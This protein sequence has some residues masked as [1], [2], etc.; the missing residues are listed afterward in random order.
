[1]KLRKWLT[2]KPLEWTGQH[3]LYAAPPQTPCQPLKGSV[4][5][6]AKAKPPKITRASDAVLSGLLENRENS[7]LFCLVGRC[8]AWRGWV[9]GRRSAH[10]VADRGHQG[11]PSVFGA[12]PFCPGHL[13]HQAETA[14]LEWQV[15]KPPH[16]PINV[17]RAA[18]TSLWRIS[19][20]PTS[21]ASA[22]ALSTRS[23]SSRVN[24]PDSLTTRA[25][26]CR[27][28]SP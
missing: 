22:P 16:P 8:V 2:N 7:F 25:P 14:G 1:M 18:L 15:R 24:R 6:N 20:S 3:Q 10:S 27:R 11:Q 4:I 17:S 5:D 19:A 26:R 23:R 12:D 13:L 21:T 28:A 9:S